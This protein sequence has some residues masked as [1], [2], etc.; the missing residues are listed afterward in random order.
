MTT[1]SFFGYIESLLSRRSTKLIILVATGFVASLLIFL[2][3]GLRQVN[4]EV[5]TGEV[6]PKDVIAPRSITYT[7]DILTE[8]ARDKA[9]DNTQLVYLPADLSVTRQQLDRLQTVLN[10]IDFV[11]KD[12]HSTHAEKLSDIAAL[13]DVRINNEL[14]EKILAMDNSRWQTL[15]QETLR[16]FEQIMR[17]TI[18][19]YQVE[20]IRQNVSSYISFSFTEDQI[21]II[22]TLARPYI[23]PNSIYSEEATLNARLSAR[24]SVT[25]IT[26]TF[27]EGE[28]VVDRGHIITEA[29][30]EALE[31]LGL[32]RPQTRIEDILSILCIV[33]IC[34]AFTGLFFQRRKFSITF[35][36]KSVLAISSLFLLFLLGARFAIPARV[37]LPYIYPLAAFGLT[38]SCL[39]NVEIGLIFSIII[40]ILATFDTNTTLD[41]TIYY[42]ISSLCGVL[43]LG[44]GYRFANFLWTGITIG[45]AGS[46]TV[47]AFRLTDSNIDF[48]GITTLVGAAFL[49]GIASASIAIVLQFL[50]SQLLGLTTA[51]RLLDLSRPDHPLLQFILFNA[52]GTYQHSLQV[53]NLA[54][55]A[56]DAIGADALLT[57]VGALYHDAGKASNPQYFIENQ[58]PGA[59]NPH[60]QLD[61]I[62]S[63]EIILHHVSDGINL[64]NQYHLSP[65][66]KDFILE[67]HGTLITRYQYAKAVE[68]N[69][70]NY[71]EQTPFKY[72]GPKPES[73]ET[74]ILMLADVCEAK[75]RAELPKDENELRVLVKKVFDYVQQEEQ[76]DKTNLT[77]RDLRIISETFV[78]ILKN[79]HHPRI[80][81]PEPPAQPLKSNNQ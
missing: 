46:L 61:P 53:A 10:Y 76:L 12:T 4:L 33:A 44:R 49:N 64:A 14:S 71:V 58:V 13:S 29:D 37:V 1:Y 40:S 62:K 18:K 3:I 80:L 65:R 27:L 31:K 38:L 39:F 21:S 15:Q 59:N 2:P 9:E 43:V 67:H 19:D 52:P 51:L 79:T 55:R 69:G 32:K 25:P 23:I 78:S 24:A 28:T 20:T 56:A 5:K 35:D 16:V 11:S 8:E 75:A 74:A 72:A 36:T 47:M 26:R 30:I 17:N 81:Y 63:A 77:L 66:V 42:C 70:G 45:V 60:S 41:L 34:T 73:K 57:R 7:S 68:L 48:I 54:E 22:S 50:F 6:S